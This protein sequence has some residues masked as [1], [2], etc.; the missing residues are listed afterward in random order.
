MEIAAAIGLV[1]WK[2]PL[3]FEQ[4]GKVYANELS[5]KVE[6]TFDQ[7][8]NRRLEQELQGVVHKIPGD[9]FNIPQNHPGLLGK[10]DA[11]FVQNLEHFFNPIQHQE[12]LNLLEKLLTDSGRA[13]LTAHT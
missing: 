10:V 3:A 6:K 13:F 2:I 8:L 7:V 4:T 12:F 1:T 9:C 11:I 5:S